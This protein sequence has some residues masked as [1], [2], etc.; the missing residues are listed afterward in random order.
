VREFHTGVNLTG[1]S[2]RITARGRTLQ[3]TQSTTAYLDA[4]GP[5]GFSKIGELAAK[6]NPA[7]PCQKSAHTRAAHTVHHRSTVHSPPRHLDADGLLV[8][9]GLSEIGQLAAK[10]VPKP[11]Q[12]GRKNWTVHGSPEPWYYINTSKT[13]VYYTGAVLTPI[14]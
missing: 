10:T 13:D 11:C 9:C 2:P 3:L 6:K 7:K 14:H 5:S 1:W 8:A 12:R 4:D